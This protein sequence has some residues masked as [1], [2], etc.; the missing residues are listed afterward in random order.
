M[1]NVDILVIGAGSGGLAAAKRATSLGARVAI[2]ESRAV[3]GTCVNRGC[4]PKKLLVNAAEFVHQQQV[5]ASLQWVNPTGL[6]DW[7]GLKTAIANHLQSIRQSQQETLQNA[8]IDV[9]QG[10]AHFL[11]PHIAEIDGKKV[12]AEHI[13]EV[14]H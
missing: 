3:G 6:L 8:G 7:P 1:T 14:P 2:A 5:A 10:V 12:E 4:V 11:D 13:A 9:I